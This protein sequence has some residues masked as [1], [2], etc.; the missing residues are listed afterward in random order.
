AEKFWSNYNSSFSPDNEDNKASEF[1]LPRG[2]GIDVPES[3]DQFCNNKQAEKASLKLAVNALIDGIAACVR[4]L[5]AFFN[6]LAKS[7]R[8]AAP[9]ASS[10]GLDN[11]PSQGQAETKSLL[12]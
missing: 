4:H 5:I 1:I 8:R 11:R 7:H 6:N 3:H 12:S 10:S 2:P 9:A